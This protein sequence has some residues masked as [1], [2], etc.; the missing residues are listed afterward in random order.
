MTD[1]PDG[2]DRLHSRLVQGAALGGAALISFGLILWIAA[3]WTDIGRHGRFALV[4]GALV[5][6][7]V[8]GMAQHRLRVPGTLVA[9]AA[10]GGLFALFGQVYQSGAD[11]WQLFA[12]WAALGLPLALAARHDVL[13]VPWTAVTFTAI[14]L[15]ASA[16]GLRP[17]QGGETTIL[18]S[19]AL[20]YA[21]AALLLAIGR[22]WPGAT[23]FAFRLAML[24]TLSLVTGQA[25]VVVIAE[26]LASL[27]ALA[28]LALLAGTATACLRLLNG[29]FA[30]AAAAT[31]GF[32]IVLITLVARLYTSAMHAP[33]IF[34]FML[35]GIIAAGIIAGSATLLLRVRQEAEPSQPAVD[36]THHTW[37][38]TVL[39]GI[40]AIFAAIPFLF[41][42][43]V[44]FGGFTR[45]G[46]GM[47]VMGALTI[48]GSV[49]VLRR[50]ANLGFRQQFGFIM[51]V[52]GGVL[53][54]FALLRD[55]PLMLAT[56]LMLA[57]GIG[58]TLAIPVAWIRMLLGA[59]GAA[60]AVVLLAKGLHSVAGGGL[61]ATHKGAAI[62]LGLI[63]AGGVWGERLAPIRRAGELARAATPYLTGFAV[64]ALLTL[65]G[66]A[67]QTFLLGTHG[68]FAGAGLAG[69]AAASSGWAAV[70]VGSALAGCLLLARFYPQLRSALGGII[71]LALVVFSALLYPLGPTILI[72]AAALVTAR[73]GI[74]GLGAVTALWIAGAFYYW[75]GWPLAHK[76]L[77]LAGAGTILVLAAL[78]SGRALPSATDVP[79]GARPALA[80]ALIGLSLTATAGI[81][82]TG[83]VAKERILR[84][85]LVLYIPLAPVDPRSLMQGDY[86]AL[87]FA[88]P[89]DRTSQALVDDPALP[90]IAFITIDP[91]HVATVTRISARGAPPGAD[92]RIV[93]LKRKGGRW[94]L[95][96]DA[97]FFEEGQANTFEQARFGAF[98]LSRDGELLLTGMADKDLNLLGSALASSAS[99]RR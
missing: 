75:L 31:L 6:A 70:S 54:S 35:I 57:I 36:D 89:S 40:G 5:V 67:G 29:E 19:W 33:G 30:L 32:D 91:R 84:K 73:I 94:V 93:R 16:M 86:M 80:A 71:G 58:L 34:G 2:H 92:E 78:K 82:L 83:F 4:G 10:I 25:A 43:F 44:A 96:T 87:R 12:L 98:R 60:A 47:Y 45:H 74:A 17:L 50:A 3:N 20:A 46:A 1:G 88:L 49:A 39:S 8:A 68:P 65:A 14:P 41:A 23:R 55:A 79:T 9:F 27:P 18:A 15:W 72:T 48:A 69:S 53:L 63:A 42:Y 61:Y 97:W 66:S 28:G 81:F 21:V 51:L 22:R 76:A 38:V 90:A 7:G 95:G 11:P 64:A 24:L 56:A 37:P 99:A 85:G 59:A 52:V 77:L 26:G 13:F 62:L